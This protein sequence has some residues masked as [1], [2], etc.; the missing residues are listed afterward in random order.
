MPAP[1]TYPMLIAVNKIDKEGAAPERIRNEL[2]ADGLTPEEWG[3]DGLR[4][5]L[6]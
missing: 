2:A 5:R 3:R 1:P 6:R 4:R